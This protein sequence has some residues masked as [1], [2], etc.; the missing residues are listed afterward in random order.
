MPSLSSL[1]GRAQRIRLAVVL[2]AAL[3]VG[4]HAAPA[5]SVPELRVVRRFID[6][7][8]RTAAPPF[9]H[10]GFESIAGVRKLAVAAVTPIEPSIVCM[11]PTESASPR[12][13]CTVSV[14]RSELSIPALIV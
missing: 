9:T 12:R 2:L 13:P 4:C 14:P 11:A 5:P 8:F 10:W 6:D 7:R 1:A 3:A